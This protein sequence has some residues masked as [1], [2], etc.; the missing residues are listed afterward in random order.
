MQPKL[1][2]GDI[3]PIELKVLYQTGR[4]GLERQEIRAKVFRHMFTSVLINYAVC[5]LLALTSFSLSS[6]LKPRYF[7]TDNTCDFED[8]EVSIMMFGSSQRVMTFIR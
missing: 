5:N 6:D 2:D 3:F 7:E 1:V 8:G 4:E